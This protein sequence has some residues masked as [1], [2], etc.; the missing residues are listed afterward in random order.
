[1]AVSSMGMLASGVL[2]W[3]TCRLHPHL[4]A[5]GVDVTPRFYITRMMPVGFFMA[6]ADPDPGGRHP[7]AL[8]GASTACFGAR[9]APLAALAWK[10]VRRCRHR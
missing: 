4:A 8:V 1:M 9:W 5:S 3:V 10:G 7:C 6:G 2:S